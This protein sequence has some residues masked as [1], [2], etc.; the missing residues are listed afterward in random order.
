MKSKGFTLTEILVVILIVLLLAG[1]LM[2]LVV[3]A[4]LSA[5][6]T[7]CATN[8]KQAL[9]ALNIYFE[10]HGEYPMGLSSSSEHPDKKER[11][12]SPTTAPRRNTNI[13]LCPLDGNGGRKH[14]AL[15]DR[16]EPRSY[17]AFWFLWEGDQGI[18]AWHRLIGMD[19][20]PVLLRCFFHDDRLRGVLNRKGGY[21]DS[22]GYGLGGVS[23]AGR[24]D[25]SVFFDTKRRDFE[26]KMQP[27]GTSV[28]DVKTLTWSYATHLP[29][30]TDI[31][32]GQDPP[33]GFNE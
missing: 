23:L 6:R 31:C 15:D 9:V 7:A 17:A 30:P 11:R 10:E 22:F 24:M 18:V 21:G 27:D 2:P 3:Q 29:C 14:R 20:S 5:K 16:D 28:L 26:M 33:E 4:K 32:D 25:G 13:F 1:L 19:S 8:M 12:V